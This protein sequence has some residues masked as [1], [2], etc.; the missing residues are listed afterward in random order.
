[1]DLARSSQII[2]KTIDHDDDASLRLAILLYNTINPNF[3]L[4]FEDSG[5][6]TEAE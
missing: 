4:S 2:T 3:H 1:M 5:T 6:G